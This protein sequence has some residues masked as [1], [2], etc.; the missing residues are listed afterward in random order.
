[1][2]QPDQVAVGARVGQRIVAADQQRGRAGADIVKQRLGDLL[3]AADQRGGV[4]RR[5]GDEGQGRPQPLAV[6]V[7]ARRVT[8]QPPGAFGLRTPVGPGRTLA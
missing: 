8:Q 7:S 2:D 4:P 5:P 3:I 1:M 6:Q